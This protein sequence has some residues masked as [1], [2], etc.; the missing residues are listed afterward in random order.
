[1]D[2]E[3]LFKEID[4]VSFVSLTQMSSYAKRAGCL[5]V[6]LTER[7]AIESRQKQ[8]HAWEKLKLDYER[9]SSTVQ[10]LPDETC[11]EIMVS[12]GVCI[13][14]PCGGPCMRLCV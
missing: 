10:T 2:T 12:R 8:I 6:W 3:V 7:Q 9:L 4:K 14:L 11:H 1:M 13:G 5:C